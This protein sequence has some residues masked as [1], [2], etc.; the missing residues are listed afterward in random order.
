LRGEKNWTPEIREVPDPAK[1]QSNE[2]K[3]KP[4]RETIAAMMEG[5]Y[6][7]M[8]TALLSEEQDNLASPGRTRLL[9]RGTESLLHHQWQ[10]P[11]P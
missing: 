6:N 7:S 1:G 3:K 10:N 8:G 5:G 11:K 4:R 9:I 2:S